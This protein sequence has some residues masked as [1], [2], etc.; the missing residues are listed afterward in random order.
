MQLPRDGPC[1]AATLPG[2]DSQ[3]VSAQAVAMGGSCTATARF[4]TARKTLT[5][6]RQACGCRLR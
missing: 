2:V 3:L 4:I 1:C 5:R 6:D